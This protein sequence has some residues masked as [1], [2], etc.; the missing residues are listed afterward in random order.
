MVFTVIM[1]YILPE[2]GHYNTSFTASVHKLEVY[3]SHQSLKQQ[4]HP[5]KWCACI[6]VSTNSNIAACI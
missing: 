6:M 3:D 1:G 5:L 2:S 4:H